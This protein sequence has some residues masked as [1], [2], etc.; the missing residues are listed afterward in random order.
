MIGAFYAEKWNRVRANFRS[1][2]LIPHIHRFSVF[3]EE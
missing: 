3:D 2:A 1:N